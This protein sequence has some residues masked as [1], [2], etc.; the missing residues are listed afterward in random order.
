MYY[1]V[2][3]I[4]DGTENTRKVSL[5]DYRKIDR[6]GK[7]AVLNTYKGVFGFDTVILEAEE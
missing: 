3:Y 6:E 1:Y 5:H 7:G 4:S 2:S